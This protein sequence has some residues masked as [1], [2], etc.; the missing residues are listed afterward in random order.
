MSLCRNTDHLAL[1]AVYRR[2]ESGVDGIRTVIGRRECPLEVAFA[3]AACSRPSR[4]L[5]R[6]LSGGGGLVSVHQCAV[7]IEVVVSRTAHKYFH[8]AGDLLVARSHLVAV[9]TRWAL[10]LRDR[11]EVGTQAFVGIDIAIAL[12]HSARLAREGAVALGIRSLLR[13]EHRILFDKRREW[14]ASP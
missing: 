12:D 14:P 2:R 8:T 11:R 1:I 13:D 9:E 7:G 6:H 3:Q 5:S 10:M 4:D